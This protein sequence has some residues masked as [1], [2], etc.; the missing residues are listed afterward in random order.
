VRKTVLVLWLCAMVVAEGAK[1][2][3]RAEPDPTFSFSGIKT[4]AWDPAGGGD[5]LLARAADD[6][7]AVVKRR[8]DPVITA[9]VESELA[10]RGLTLVTTGSP[11]I[12]MHY[13]L[14]VTV[15]FDTQTMGQFLPA[16]P[17]WGVPPFA[18]STS[19]L[20]IIQRGSIVLDAV[21]R[22]L[23][24]VIWRGVAQTD[25]DKIK[26]DAERDKIIRDSVRDLVKKLPLNK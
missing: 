5:V 13:Y 12:T 19:S 8:V 7:P 21:S 17:M 6:D 10:G 23:A 20:N 11:D 26:N 25:I 2:K 4:W 15:G 24:R 1:I 22:S 16:V 3:V 14:L 18:P 9:A